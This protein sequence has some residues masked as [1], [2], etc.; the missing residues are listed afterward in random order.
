[1]AEKQTFEKAL[2]QLE[3]CAQQLAGEEITL[4]ESMALYSSGVKLAE[5]CKKALTKA[6]LRLQT[7]SEAESE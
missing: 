2:L 6:Q 7:V 5:Y 3:Q 4:E 1:M